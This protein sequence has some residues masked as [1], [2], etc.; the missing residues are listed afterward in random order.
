[1][2]TAMMMFSNARGGI[3]SADATLFIASEAVPAVTYKDVGGCET[4][5]KDE[6]E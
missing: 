5:V 2:L 3:E 6:R 1:M 4:P